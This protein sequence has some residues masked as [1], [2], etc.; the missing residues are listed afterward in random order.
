MNSSVYFLK[1]FA[2]KKSFRRNRKAI[3]KSII[4]K[5]MVFLEPSILISPYAYSMLMI[6]N[7]ILVRVKVLRAD[8]LL[9]SI[10]SILSNG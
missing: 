7:K 5:I 4:I 8:F 6:M 9:L 1:A 10:L 3:S 2:R